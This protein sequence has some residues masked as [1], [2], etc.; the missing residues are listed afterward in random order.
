MFGIS[1]NQSGSFYRNRAGTSGKCG[2]G[3]NGT[4]YRGC[5]TGWKGTLT[6]DVSRGHYVAKYYEDTVIGT[7]IPNSEYYETR[8]SQTVVVTICIL[9][10][11]VS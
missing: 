9:L 2:G 3:E 5:Q 7:F 6:I 1:C 11:L 10:I 4:I 8:W